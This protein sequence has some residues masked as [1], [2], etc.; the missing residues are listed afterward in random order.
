MRLPGGLIILIFL[1]TCSTPR[2]NENQLAVG[3]EADTTASALLPRNPT[4]TLN[5]IG[6]I[7]KFEDNQSFY[8]DLYFVDGFNDD[9]Y[10]DITK[11]GDKVIFKDEETKRTRIEI[12]KAGQ[13]FNL[14][15]LHTITIYNRNNLALT[16]GRLSHIEYVED[17]ID[18]KFV[19]VFDVRN[20]D[21]SD[22]L[23]CIGNMRGDLPTV[24]VSSYDDKKL[25]SDLITYLKL[26]T[27]HVW[28]ITYY[29]LDDQTTYSTVSADTTAF[30]VETTGKPYQT[31]YKSKS[32][33]L[34]SQLTIISKKI[35]GRQILLTISGMPETDMGWS[36]VLIFNGTEYEISKDHRIKNR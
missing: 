30:I 14:T 20:P 23:F 21:I 28:G 8:T 32:S 4:D 11:M 33:E 26:S 36:S 1:T 6:Y 22:Y 17:L 5:Y 13:Y 34:I 18:N 27:D 2:S 19:A 16:T 3:D 31:L 9:L 10:D 25:D 24:K 12:K 29:Q 15:G 7:Q 35:N